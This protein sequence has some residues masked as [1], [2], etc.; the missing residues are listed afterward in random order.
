MLQMCCSPTC[1]SYVLSTAGVSSRS[2]NLICTSCGRGTTALLW[3]RFRYAPSDCL[4]TFPFPLTTS[5]VSGAGAHYHESRQ[6]LMLARQ[7]G[8]TKTYNRFH[9]PKEAAEDI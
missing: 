3:T 1:S 9:D 4:D 8:L 2:S 5:A 7:E 6:Q